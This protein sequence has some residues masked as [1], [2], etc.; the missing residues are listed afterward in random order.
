M[1]HS[2]KRFLALGAIGAVALLAGCASAAGTTVPTAEAGDDFDWSA[3]EAVELTASSVFPPGST[4]QVLE[5]EWMAAVTKA[6]EGKVT[7]EYFEG[8]VLHPVTEAISALNSG[9]TDVTFVNNGYFADQ[10][11]ISN[12]DDA[13]MQTA[14]SGFGYPNMNIA[15]IGQQIVHHSDPDTPARAEMTA[16]GFIPILPMLSGPQGLHC[17]KPFASPADLKGRTVRVPYPIAQEE[18]ESLGMT[19]MFLPPNEVYEALQRGIIDCALNATT[20]ILAGGLLEVS[21][22]VA[23][24][25]TAPSPG[26]NIAIS[27]AAWDGLIPEIQ[28]VMLDARYK[29]FERF[30]RDTLDG[31]ADIVTAAKDAGGGV[32]DAAKLNPAIARYWA[33][34]PDPV[35]SAP[36]GVAD[37]KADVKRTNAI[38]EAWRD[39]AVNELGVPVD[40]GDIVE[41][42]GRGSGVMDDAAWDAWS[43]AIIDGLGVR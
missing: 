16:K 2:K 12:W 43:K 23:F 18:L 31:Y 36:A 42:L 22:W 20:N 34:R 29:P 28:Q 27:T 39:F 25:N 26:A 21:P 14:V 38:T 4:A 3:V 7:F 41:V 30:A 37:P 17:A 5:T 11:P 1:E 9:L 35:N 6:T 40:G 13:I 33:G 8:G 32:I 24:P 15:G 19:G 10:L